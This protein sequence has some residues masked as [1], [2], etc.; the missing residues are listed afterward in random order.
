[1]NKVILIGRITR[2][3]EIKYT[4]QG[5]AVCSFTLAV[6]RDYKGE[7]G[8]NDVDFISCVAWRSQ[9]EF[10]ANYIKKGYL[11]AISGIIQSRMYQTQTGEKRVLTEVVV[12]T[13]KSLTPKPQSASFGNPPS[14]FEVK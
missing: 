12:D 13:I 8:N 7:Q 4:P 2:D 10:L 3:A 5:A 6:D 1:M 11:L 9:A 14:S